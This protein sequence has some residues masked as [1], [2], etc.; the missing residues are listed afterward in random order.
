MKSGLYDVPW[1]FF[2]KDTATTE[3]YTLSLHDALP[4]CARLSRAPS[5]GP[6]HASQPR[7]S[8]ATW[9]RSTH[10]RGSR[11]SVRLTTNAARAMPHCPPPSRQRRGPL[12]RPPAGPGGHRREHHLDRQPA[13]GLGHRAQ[14]GAM[15]GRDRADDGQP[16]PQP[17]APRPRPVAPRTSACAPRARPV[18][19]RTSTSAP[20]TEPWPAFPSAPPA[21]PGVQPLERLEEPA[22]LVR[23]DDRAGV[24]HREE[25]PAVPFARADLDPAAGHVVPDRVVG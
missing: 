18:A 22:E 9:Q 1:F 16:Q 20:R 2:F 23:R 19:S 21:P 6:N 5:A 24:A 12:L 17:A 13:R 15:R 10:R 4:I 25:R 3:I 11:S 7:S 14:F 8:A